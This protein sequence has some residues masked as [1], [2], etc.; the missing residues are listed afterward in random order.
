MSRTGALIEAGVV[1]N[2]IVWGDNSQTQFEAEGWDVAMETTNVTPR[3]GIGWTWTEADG[4]RP[5]SPYPSWVWN[6]VAWEAPVPQP[7]GEYSW[8]EETQT[9]DEIVTGDTN[10]D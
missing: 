5:P 1:Q 4:F 3:P 10:G 9:W 8:N 2:I 7:E 6:G